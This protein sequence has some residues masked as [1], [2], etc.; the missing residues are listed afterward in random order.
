MGKGG[1]GEVGGLGWD[2]NKHWRVIR[3]WNV[4][5]CAGCHDGG[6]SFELVHVFH[7]ALE[8]LHVRGV[9]WGGVLVFAYSSWLPTQTVYLPTQTST[10]LV[11]PVGWE[12]AGSHRITKPAA[13]F[14]QF[15]RS[16]A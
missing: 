2:N 14:S 15:I 4:L 16:D 9:G 8:Y 1:V 3:C 12:V 5:E 6:S 11:G 7:A 13:F 10:I